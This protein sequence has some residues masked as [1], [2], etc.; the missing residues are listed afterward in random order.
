MSL[1]L[2]EHLFISSIDGS[3]YD[4][5]NKGW[6]SRPPLRPNYQYH[7]PV[8]KNNNELKAVL[9][10]GQFSWLGGYQL[11]MVDAYS[12]PMSF[13]GVEKEFKRF[14]G[15]DYTFDFP[16]AVFPNYHDD[17]LYCSITGKQIPMAYG[18]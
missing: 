17:M 12:Q 10:A 9:R 3:L 8:I 11:F 13:E 4:T 1:N 18:E 2:P 15:A 5:R 6:A 16:I 14:R 7:F